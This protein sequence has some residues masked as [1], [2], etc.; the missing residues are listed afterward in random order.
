VQFLIILALSIALI[1]VL[2]S[3]RRNRRLLLRWRSAMQAPG[4]EQTKELEKA[5]EDLRT[6]QGEL[7]RRWRYLAEAQR[8]SHS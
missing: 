2:G 6:A 5:N 3:W 4:G 8:L 7:E 1:A